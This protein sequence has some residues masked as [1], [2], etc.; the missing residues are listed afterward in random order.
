M[1]ALI[2]LLACGGPPGCPDADGDGYAAC[3]DAPDDCDDQN[4]MVHPEAAEVCDDGVDNDCS[5]GETAD[6]AEGTVP[7]DP[8]AIPGVLTE[9][10]TCGFWS[11]PLDSHLFLDLHIRSELPDCLLSL[12]P[13]LSSPNDPIYTNLTGDGPKYTYDIIADAASEET[14]IGI[15]CDEGTEWEALVRVE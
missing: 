10:D 12:G 2:A 8:A 14:T 9:V 1:I 7:V 15:A 13:S 6:I 5:G 4:A 3:D 11:M